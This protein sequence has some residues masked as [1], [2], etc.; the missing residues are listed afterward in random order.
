MDNT[1]II[2]LLATFF[3]MLIMGVQ[4]CYA[5]IGSA[6]ITMS[7]LGLSMNLLIS[8]LIDGVDGF[9]FLA[10]PFFVLAGEIMSQGG[11][12]RRLIIMANALVGWMRGGLAQVNI[13]ASTFFGGISGSALA[14]T[15]SLGSILIPMMKD[16]GYDG[17][18]STAITMTSS[19]QGLLI[20]P[21]HNMVIY[22]M[23]AGGVSISALFMAGLTPG[24]LLGAALMIYTYFISKKRNYPK[25]DKFS[26]KRLLKATADSILGLGTV[27]VVVVCVMTCWYTAKVSAAV[28]CLWALIVS[29]VFYREI[30]PSAIFN[31]LGATVKTLASVLLLCAAAGTF[32]FVISYL[33]IPRLV[34]DAFL[35]FTTSKYLILLLINVL[36]LGLGMITGMSSI[37]I[38]TTPI[39]L[40]V[41]QAVGVS[42][43][44]YGAILILNCG[45]GLITPPVGGVLFMGSSISGIKIERLIKETFPQLLVMILVLLLVTYIPAITMWPSMIGWLG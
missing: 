3:G 1:A 35:S 38:I 32:G 19:V 6:L 22:S 41:L 14:D 27:I 45:I 20:P 13:V 4:I 18:F 23:A 44:Q 28:A 30:K 25:G 11:I 9:T 36:I 39:L 2:I 31:I 42:P 37:I 29:F 7:Y 8:T 5:M 26:L 15:A 43:I 10:V 34:A 40:P 17:E 33:R 21:S 16:E 24:L 12:A